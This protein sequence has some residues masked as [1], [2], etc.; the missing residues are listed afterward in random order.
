M[1]VVCV[2]NRKVLWRAA[3]IIAV[4]GGEMNWDETHQGQD[5]ASLHLFDEP[6]APDTE[7]LGADS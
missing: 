3:V 7:R 4:I 2:R 1:L 6:P 5:T